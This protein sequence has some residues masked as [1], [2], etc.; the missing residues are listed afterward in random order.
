MDAGVVLEGSHPFI[1]PRI[2]INRS[3][4]LLEFKS[5][6]LP[7]NIFIRKIFKNIIKPIYKQ[8]MYNF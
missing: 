3:L 6:L 1:I 5:S 2:G 4:N 7:L 8:A